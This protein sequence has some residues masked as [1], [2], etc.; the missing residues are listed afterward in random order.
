MRQPVLGCLGVSS[1]LFAGIAA[2][3][4]SGPACAQAK[5]SDS[6]VKVSAAAGKA[7]A[8]GKQVVTVTL[9]MDKGWHTYANPVGL[10]DLKAA[11]TVVTV[12]GKEK[13]QE[14]KVD[15]PPGRL[16]K[17]KIVGDYKVYD[18]KVEIKTTIKRTKGDTGPLEATV[19]FQ[20]CTETTCLLPAI[21]KVKVP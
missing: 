1:L 10:D 17:D 5:K 13:L 3:F 8:D 19:K 7:D 6:V 15:Y 12:A 14:M 11:Q 18:D 2:V 21:V 4:T 20:A 16:I 9:T